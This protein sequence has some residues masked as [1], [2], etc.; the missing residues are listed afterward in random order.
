MSNSKI[1]IPNPVHCSLSVCRL[2]AGQAGTGRFTVHPTPT[3]TLLRKGGGTR[4]R[5]GSA[6]IIVLLLVTILT[7]L[8]VE[9][10][11]EVYIGTSALSNWQ[12]AQ[13]ASFLSKSGQ[14]LSLNYIKNL[15]GRSYTSISDTDLPDE[16]M[17]A[18][19]RN[20][21]QGALKIKIIDENSKLNIN[22]IV[23]PNGIDRKSVV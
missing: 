20:E 9:F 2:P 22:G 19:I 13:K 18:Q 15:A 12:N 6:L 17:P 8:A 21:E 10:A 16:I 4:G 23:Y 7:G 11:Y 3:L 5:E 14:V 1:Q